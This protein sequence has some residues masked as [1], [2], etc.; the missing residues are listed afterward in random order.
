SGL[1]AGALAGA[2]ARSP[3][4]RDPQHRDQHPSGDLPLSIFNEINSA[5]DQLS[6]NPKMTRMADVKI[7]TLTNASQDHRY[8]RLFI[9]LTSM[10]GHAAG[11][12]RRKMFSGDLFHHRST[13]RVFQ[14]S[15][16]IP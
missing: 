3:D 15:F 8:V 5:E 2:G 9:C 11:S 16:D 14:A 4:Q 13:P 6:S 12:A 7:Q 10:F 1:H